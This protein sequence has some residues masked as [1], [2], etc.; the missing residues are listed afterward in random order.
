MYSHLF[1]HRQILTCNWEQAE[2]EVR[3]LDDIYHETVDS[4]VRELAAAPDVLVS[5]PGLAALAA[6]LQQARM[7]QGS[8]PPQGNGN[9]GSPGNGN[10]NLRE[11]ER[12]SR[13]MVTNGSNGGDG[14]TDNVMSQ[15]QVGTLHTAHCTLHTAH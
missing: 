14:N 5:H 4:V 3:R 7:E 10:A 2:A 1:S 15:S 9:G 8:S 13:S 6:S 11:R 12:M